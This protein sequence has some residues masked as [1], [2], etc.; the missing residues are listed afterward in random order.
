[1][2]LGLYRREVS[3]EAAQPWLFPR[4]VPYQNMGVEQKKCVC[5]SL[6]AA[7]Q[8]D[9]LGEER[10]AKRRRLL[11]TRGGRLAE[12]AGVRVK[13]Q[14]IRGRPSLSRH[15]LSPAAFRLYCGVCM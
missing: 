2:L 7:V 5:V 14:L 4:L 1:M 10:E 8:S 11:L 6:P 12:R 9:W 13:L 3:E 15:L